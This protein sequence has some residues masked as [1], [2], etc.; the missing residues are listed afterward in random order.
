MKEDHNSVLFFVLS[1]DTKG[2]GCCRYGTL[3]VWSTWVWD[4]TASMGCYV[5]V[6]MFYKEGKDTLNWP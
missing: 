3:Q 6:A 1:T 5:M 4:T 2:M